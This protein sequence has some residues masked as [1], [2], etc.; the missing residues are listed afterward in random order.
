M[1]T[2][3]DIP[4][5]EVDRLRADAARWFDDASDLTRAGDHKAATEAAGQA[6]L[7]LALFAG[8]KKARTK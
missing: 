2:A 3:E 1:T 7:A 6:L 5:K 4:V 8:A